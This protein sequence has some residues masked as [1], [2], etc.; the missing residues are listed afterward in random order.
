MFNNFFSKIEQF[1][2][3]WKKYCRAGQARDKI[4]RMRIASWITKATNSHPEYVIIIAF[5]LQHWLNQRALM[6]R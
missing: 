2:S 3:M 4:W 6:F 5:P 1:M